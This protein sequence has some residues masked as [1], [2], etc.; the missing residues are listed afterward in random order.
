MSQSAILLD[1]GGWNPQPWVAAIRD[2]DP[3]RSLQ[4]APDLSAPS[5]IGYALVWNPPQGLLSRL[6]NLRAIFSLG[7]G[8]DSILSLPDLPAVPIVRV[9]NP[10]LTQRMTEWIVLQVL[11]HHRQQRFYDRQQAAR[12]WRELSQPAANEVRVGIMGLGVLGR[13]AARSLHHLGFDVAGWSRRPA[14]LSDI[15]CFHGRDGLD[16]L[17]ARTDILVSL[18]P[19][20]PETRGILAMPLLEKLARDGVLG[21]PILI[22]AGRGTLQVEADVVQA[23]ERGILI[24]ASL[25]VFESEPLDAGSPLWAMP[26]VIVT[27][28]AAAA[29]TAMAIVPTILDQIRDFE[30]GKPLNNVVDRGA[31]Y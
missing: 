13:A 7:A 29:S 3:G 11:L 12:V 17:L 6:P 22:N 5:E 26:N 19:L 20:T 10:D 30:A 1:T 9:V 2:Y 15:A 18:L 8:V 14:D 25:D 23:L 24:G 4:I 27:P 28:H 31:M 21:G 16:R